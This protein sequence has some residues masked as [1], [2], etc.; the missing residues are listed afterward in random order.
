VNN[1]TSKEVESVNFS[2]EEESA[3]TYDD[4]VGICVSYKKRFEDKEGSI[5]AENWCSEFSTTCTS[6][7]R[8]ASDQGCLRN[9]AMN[10]ANAYV[11]KLLEDRRNKIDTKGSLN[12]LL[13]ALEKA[14]KFKM[15]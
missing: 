2:D 6:A 12:R 7:S 15:V 1:V 3:L 5:I 9:I 11:E 13:S 10:K 8:D 4:T 14:D